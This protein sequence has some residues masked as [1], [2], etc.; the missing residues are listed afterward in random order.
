MEQNNPQEAT[1][2]TEPAE[3]GSAQSQTSAKEQSSAAAGNDQGARAQ[4]PDEA[5]GGAKQEETAPKDEGGLLSQTDEDEEDESASATLGAPEGDYTFEPTESSV[6]MDEES[7]KAFAEVAKELNLSNDAAQKI[8]SKMEPMLAASI[9]RNRAVWAEQAKADKEYGGAN[10]ASNMKAVHRVYRDTTSEG[11][12]K[13]LKASGLDSHPEV[14]RHFYGLSKILGEGRI[15]TSRGTKE[16]ADGRG[17]QGFY[18]G[19]NP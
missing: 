7:M 6:H 1:P 18:K 9:T 19:M 15:V 16:S 14:I 3:G 4:I 5:G 11:L 10:F 2:T 13:V 12:R 17:L 8:V